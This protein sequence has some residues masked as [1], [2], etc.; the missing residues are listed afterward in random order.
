MAP[1]LDKYEQEGSAYYSTARLWDDGIIDPLDTRT[2]LALGL[3]R[4]LQRA[5]PGHAIRRVPHVNGRT[6]PHEQHAAAIAT[7]TMARP[8][9]HNAFNEALIAELT[10]PRSR[11]SATD[12]AASHRAGRRGQSFSAGA[13]L[14][15]MAAHGQLSEADKPR[16]RP[17]PRRHAPRRRRMPEAGGRAR[18][19]SGH[20]RRRGLAAAA[21]IAI[22]AESAMFAF[23]EVRLG[24]IPATI[25]PHVIEKIGAGRALPLF[26]TG[27]RF[28]SVFAA[29][30]GLVHRS[31]PDDELD[32]D[33]RLR[34][35]RRCFSGGPNAQTAIKKL[36]RSVADRPREVMSNLH[37]GADRRHPRRRKRAEKAWPRSSR[38]ES[39]GGPKMTAITRVLIANRGEIAVRIATTCRALGIETVAV[40]SDADRR[41]LHVLECDRAVH[42]GRRS[43]APRATWTSRRSSRPR[44][45]RGADALHPGYGLL[46]EN[47]ALRRGLRGGRDHLHRPAGR[48]MRVMGDKAKARADRR[49]A[50]RAGVPGYEGEDQ[51]DRAAP[52]TRATAD[53]LSGD[54]QGGGGRRRSRHA[55]R[56]EAGRPSSARRRPHAGRPSAPSA[57][58]A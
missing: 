14:E 26:L 3:A 36:V 13:D 28:G 53:R 37:L 4:R 8:E 34:P 6:P 41:A 5:D 1:I 54:D 39:R 27:E 32:D 22:A 48:G 46:S 12:W 16:R 50:R 38:S 49:K 31:T 11:S 7:V 47:P 9:V 17:A 58:A 40:Y 44:G 52:R 43:Q 42:I 35:S 20:R 18:P 57:A 15:W 33:R 25:A 2:S 19:G 45:R 30:I 51:D 23:S 55:A 56:R 29:R 21:D 24:L 10:T